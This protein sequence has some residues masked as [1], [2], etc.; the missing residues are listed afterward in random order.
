MIPKIIHY[1]WL[2]SGGNSGTWPPRRQKP[3]SLVHYACVKSAIERI[4]PREVFLY[5]DREPTG[6]WWDITRP[7]VTLERVNAPLEVWG[8]RLYH[9]AHQADVIRLQKLQRKGGIYL[10]VDVFVHRSFDDLLHYRAVM[11]EQRINGIVRGLCNAVILAEP[12][13]RFLVTWHSS[14][15]SFR[16]HGTD[17][18]WDEHSVRIPYTL[19]R[20]FPEEITTLQDSAFFWPTFARDDLTLLFASTQTLDLSHTYATHLWEN[21]A[22]EPYL[23]CLTPGRV[24]EVDTNFHFWTRPLLENLA[25]NFG[26]SSAT[27]RLGRGLHKLARRMRA[28][29]RN[30]R[31]STSPRPLANDER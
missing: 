9:P 27:F 20:Q 6:P 4:G 14:Y 1:I 17:E 31:H 28:A 13:A 23:E 2:S 25:D 18:F 19:S 7:L 16:S 24:R 30:S 5:C 29:L 10:D 11:G 15:Q 21:I 22:W 12:G 3:W 26:S 8:R